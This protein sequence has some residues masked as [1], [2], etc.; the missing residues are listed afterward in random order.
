M[1]KYII[2][3]ISIHRTVH[4]VEADN[5]AEGLLIAEKADD[6]WQEWLGQQTLDVRPF[7]EEQK[8][9]FKSKEKYFWEGFISV[10]EEGYIVYNYPNGEKRIESTKIK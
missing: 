1:P 7:S 10:N 8:N 2:E 6:N 5:E 4:V 9:Y 3:Q